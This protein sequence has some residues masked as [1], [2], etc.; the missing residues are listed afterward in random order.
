MTLRK[1]PDDS[2]LR[3]MLGI[4]QCR[5]GRFSD[6][7]YLL[8]QLTEDEPGHARA[9]TALGGAYLGMGRNIEAREATEKALAM[10]P[11]LAAAQYN[12]AN[13]VLLENPKAVEEAARYYDESVKLGG[14]RDAEMEARLER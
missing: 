11:E 3:L 5:S 4:A 1:A 2:G 6:A 8:T 10:N 13:L 9:Y 12:M 14:E 7:A